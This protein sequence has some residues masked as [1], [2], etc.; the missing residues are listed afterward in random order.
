MEEK[1]KEYWPIILGAVAV[2]VGVVLV[3]KNSAASTG[4]SA[5]LAATT[6]ATDTSS[7]GSDTFNAQAQSEADAAR[8]QGLSTILSFE[9][10]QTQAD[11]ALQ[12]T[13]DSNAAALAAKTAEYNTQTATANA[14]ANAAKHSSDMQ[15]ISSIGSVIAL[16]FLF[17]YETTQAA[18]AR[19]RPYT[20]GTRREGGPA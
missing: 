20:H 16:A 9:N 6:T 15:A 18:A 5:T 12:A 3:R 14:A 4:T 11:Y 7:T 17:S 8:L 13:K 2:V 10:A 19:R 1:L